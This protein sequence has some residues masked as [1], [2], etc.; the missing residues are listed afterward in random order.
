MIT[1]MVEMK[2]LAHKVLIAQLEDIKD[3]GI[4]I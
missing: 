3:F 1:Q 2:T 4:R